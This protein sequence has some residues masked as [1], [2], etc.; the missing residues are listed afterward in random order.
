MYIPPKFKQTDTAQLYSLIQKYPF[1]T[2]VTH[3][4]AGLDAIHLPLL[5]RKEGESHQLVG[6]IA[7]ANPVWK[8]CDGQPTLIVFNGPEHY[9]SPN[10]YPTKKENGRAV[11]TWNYAVVHVKGTIQCRH[12]KEWLQDVINE[13]TNT[14]EQAQ[15]SP[16]AMDDAPDNYIDKLLQ[17]VVG[18]EV[19]IE[20]IQGKWKLSQNQPD[21]NRAGVY[22]GLSK[23]TDDKAKKMAEL[24][25]NGK[26]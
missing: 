10:Y 19:S 21:I 2:M 9:V 5:L 18:I 20:D 23:N 4:E 1:A 12:D 11:P 8:S 15:I 17:A 26:L 14:S 25:K 13:L 24:V 6:H 16:W 7:K 3:S 22:E